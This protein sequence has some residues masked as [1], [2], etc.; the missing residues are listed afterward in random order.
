MERLQ[1]LVGWVG[2]ASTNRVEHRH[3]LDLATVCLLVDYD[4]GVDV[5]SVIFPVRD[6][7]I[8]ER[9][10]CAVAAPLAFF[11]ASEALFDALIGH[12]PVNLQELVSAA[13][14]VLIDDR[15]T[16]RV[17]SLDVTPPLHSVVGR[18]QFVPHA[19]LADVLEHDVTTLDIGI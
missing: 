15:V 3:G 1:A 8:N 2:E 17:N 14:A 4:G 12:G 16:L 6:L 19:E 11:E 5:G 10:M 18:L 13:G 7:L 9:V